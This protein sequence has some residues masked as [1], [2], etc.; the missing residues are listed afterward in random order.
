[1]GAY[2]GLRS[3]RTTSPIASVP[4]ER[5]RRG[6]FGQIATQIVNPITK[7][8]Y[9]GN[10]IPVSQLSDEAVRLL[11]YYPLP[12]LPGTAN[13][14]GNNYQAPALTESNIDQLLL[15]VD[16]NIS[17]AARVYVRYNWVDAFD[18][19]GNVG[20]DRRPVPATRRT[21][22]RWCP[23][24]RRCRRRCSTTS[25]SATTASTSTR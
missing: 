2:E 25:G 13:G 9:P 12:N 14:T 18:G 8:P 1:M 6:D 15:R 20:P 24:S 5:M 19:F 3:E 7:V 11:Q 17:N 22:T 10:Q 16:Q 4:T 21:R 23:G